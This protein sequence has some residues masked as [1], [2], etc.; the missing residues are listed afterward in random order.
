MNNL[1]LPPNEWLV[2]ATE[3]VSEGLKQ[4]P[5]DDYRRSLKMRPF[6]I[7]ASYDYSM[8]VLSQLIQDKVIEI[9]DNRLR[10]I[11]FERLAWLE[12]ALLE[13]FKSAWKLVD[14]VSPAKEHH[15]KFDS[16]KL[17]IIGLKG[18]EFVIAQLRELLPIESHPL[19]KHVSLKDDSLGFDIASP[20][21]KRYGETKFLEIKTSVRPT[22]D[23]FQCFL[24]RNEFEIGKSN[25]NWALV[26]VAI[27][28]GKCKL[29]GYLQGHQIESKVPVNVDDN[30]TWET[31][32]LRVK[33]DMWLESLP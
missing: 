32:R 5:L 8:D 23:Y 19:I 12:T 13:G 6:V 33:Q 26:G 29:L 30:A 15:R 28:N 21:I 20:S 18:E 11:N 14:L 3:I 1:V 9:S 24:S 27:E 7:G 10:F 16:Q 4:T 22:N 31:I 2:V 17:A 25:P